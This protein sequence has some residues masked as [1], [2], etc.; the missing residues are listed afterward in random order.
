MFRSIRWRLVASYV[1]LALLIVA[2]VGVLAMEVVRRYALQQENNDLQANAQAV[3]RQALPLMW[4]QTR[5]RELYQLAQ[6]ASLLG[7]LRVR[8]LDRDGKVLTDSGAPGET[9]QLVWIAPPAVGTAAVGTAAVG[10]ASPKNDTEGG[11]FDWL[12]R[13]SPDG[14]S[15]FVPNFEPALVE[16]LPPGTS[17]TIVRRAY[18]PWGSRLSFETLRQRNEAQPQVPQQSEADEPRSKTVARV[19][20]GEASSPVGYVEMSSGPDFG[21]EAVGA[22]RRAL[23]FAGAGAVLLAIVFGLVVSQRMTAPL[24]VLQETTRQMAGGDLSVRAAVHGRDEIGE[25][26]GQFNQMAS[27]LQSSFQELAAERDAL[28]RFIADASHELRTPLTA[29]MNFNTLLLG[30]ASQDPEARTEFLEESQEQLKRLE[31]ITG[32]LLDLSRIDAGLVSLDF[33][34]QDVVELLEAAAAPFRSRATEKGIR[35][36]IVPPQTPKPLRCDRARLVIAISNLL[37]N[38]LKYTPR[39]GRVEIGAAQAN[40]STRLWVADSGPGIAPQDLP[41]I[42]ERFFRGQSQLEAAGSGLGL[43]IAASLVQAQGGSISAESQPGNGTRFTI[44]FPARDEKPAN[45]AS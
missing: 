12:S 7:N 23:L 25:L 17:L 13:I 44:E 14:R 43:S 6:S 24:V 16:N 10:T 18:S 5:P 29:L 34:D 8:I 36:E 4:P 39:G 28:R 32:N 9:S 21:G 26:A 19:A 31:W 27:R 1:L 37:D 45:S 20:I 40:N 38:A 22:T 11:G 42:F 2:V 33:S 41:H 35:L 30:P 3:A 15:F